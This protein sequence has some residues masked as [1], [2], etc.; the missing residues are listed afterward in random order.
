MI[1]PFTESRHTNLYIMAAEEIGLDFEILDTQRSICKI[2]N[3]KKYL[4]IQNAALGINSISACRISKDKYTTHKF[5]TKNNIPTPSFCKVFDINYKDQMHNLANNNFPVVVKPVTG[6]CGK[7]VTANIQN[8]EELD[9]AIKIIEDMGKQ[10]LILEKHIK[11][12]DYRILVFQGKIIDILERIPAYITGNG[13]NTVEELILDKNHSRTEKIMPKIVI[14]EHLNEFISLQGYDLKTIP[15]SGSKIYLRSSCNFSKGGEVRRINIHE[16]PKE[17]LHLF[18]KIQKILFLDH[19]GIDYISPDIK[20]PYK[21][22]TSGVNEVNYNPGISIHHFADKL[23][24][25]TIPMKI[26]SLYFK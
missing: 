9:V 22:I 16:V 19:C 3:G 7:G 10:R 4:L 14:D 13:N 15:S 12:K 20:K 5:L 18:K 1:K 2:G 25:I 21:E 8:P 11:G 24:N 23:D 17:N 6:V 26:L